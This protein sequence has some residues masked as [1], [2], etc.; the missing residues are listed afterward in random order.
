[1]QVSKFVCVLMTGLFAAAL[2]AQNEASVPL[3]SIDS[4][5][6]STPV[7]VKK[8]KKNRK[9]DAD[10]ILFEAIGNGNVGEVK[11][12][13]NSPFYYK[14]NEDGETALT[15]AIKQKDVPMVA[16]LTENAVINIKNAAGET[17]LTLA[18]KSGEKAIVDL[19][20][21][22]AKA[23]LKNKKGE[24]PLVLSFAYNDLFLVQTL[25]NKGADANAKSAGITPL[26]AATALGNINL[27][28]LLVK[29]KALPNIPNDDGQIPLYSAVQ[30][31][32]SIL[33]GILLYKSPTPELEANWKNDI[34]ET[35]GNLAIV[36]GNE[37]IVRL[38]LDYSY[39]P[40]IMDYMEN[41][42]LL[43]AAELGYDNIAVLFLMK[44]A[45][46]D[47]PNIMGTT[48]I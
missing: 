5:S 34:G 33:T 27:V 39:D 44:G 32:N 48:P 13:L 17:P 6:G 35:L 22:R 37:Q 9:N 30:Q 41:T 42:G 1:M 45:D 16:L 20:I 21:K 40:D 10:K 24:T 43:K 18:L 3:D 26:Y 15:L 19:V 46:P 31:G 11:E 7:S 36:Q 12:Q 28:A 29:N 8:A 4:T 23:A 47:I 38:L 2:S 25:L 14:L